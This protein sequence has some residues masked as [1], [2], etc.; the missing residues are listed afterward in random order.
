MNTCIRSYKTLHVAWRDDGM[1]SLFCYFLPRDAT[2]RYAIMQL[3]LS[4]LGATPTDWA[5]VVELQWGRGGLA[6]WKTRGGP[7]ETSG[8]R[9]YK[10]ACKMPPCNHPCVSPWLQRI[11]LSTNAWCFLLPEMWLLGVSRGPEK[12]IF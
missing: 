12:K 2:H 4:W 8:L 10:G 5:T 6:P 7:S 3:L 11:I 1:R 9:G